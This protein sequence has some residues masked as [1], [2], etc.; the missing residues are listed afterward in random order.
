MD[1]NALQKEME[2]AKMQEFMYRDATNV[3]PEM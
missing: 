2:D 3:E 1:R